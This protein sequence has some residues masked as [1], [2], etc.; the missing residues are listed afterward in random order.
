M[1]AYPCLL[2][3]RP[4]SAMAGASYNVTGYLDFLEQIQLS[5]EVRCGDDAR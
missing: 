1:L 2:R 4:R 3:Q 5:Q